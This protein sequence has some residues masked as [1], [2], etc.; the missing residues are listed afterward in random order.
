MAQKPTYEELEQ[1]V[2]ELEKKQLN[3]RT[4]MEDRLRQSEQRFREMADLS[5]SVI[6]EVDAN[7]RIMYVNTL[8]FELFGYT[9][10]DFDAGVNAMDLLAHSEDRKKAV[11]RIEQSM[12]GVRLNPGEYRVLKKNGSTIPVL[13]N[14]TPIWKDGQIIGFR[15]SV[16]DITERKKT[17]EEL[18][19]VEK[20][21]SVG[22]LA[23]GLAH[24]FNN[25]LAII[26][27]NI[28]LAKMEVA[29]GGDPSEKFSEAEIAVKRARLLTRQLLTFSRGGAVVKKLASVSDVIKE[30][31]ESALRGSNVGCEFRIADDLLLAEI[32]VDQM[33]QVIQNIVINADQ[34]MPQGGTIQ[35]CAQNTTLSATD[36][37]P[38]ETGKYIAISIQDQGTGIQHEHLSKIFDPYFT[39]KH[40]GSGLGLA[41]AYSVINKHKGNI[42]VESQMGIGSTFHIHLPASGKMALK[43]EKEEGKPIIGQGRILLMDDEEALRIMTG[44]TLES[45]GYEVEFA[46][47]GAEALDLFKDARESDKPFDVVILDLTIPGGM[48]GKETLKKL[49]EI[50]SEVRAIVCSG[51]SNDP[52]MSNFRE[53]GFS[54]MVPKP[55]ETKELSKALHEVLKG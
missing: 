1:R 13:L 10:D 46:I 27:G 15:F 4:Q 54:G 38:L 40:V 19:K 41:T 6:C 12:K 44:R 32:D 33:S 22:V 36:P 18:L 29:D 3:A 23:G 25:I 47:D 31:A 9:Q 52:V 7:L 35:V 14:S 26:M 8:G 16:T 30:A 53:Y 28:S 42:S 5:P 51:Y 34:A 55:F 20:L 45:L 21:K 2:E 43:P 24:D 37:L 11:K 49:Q 17:E 50:D 39:T 48:G